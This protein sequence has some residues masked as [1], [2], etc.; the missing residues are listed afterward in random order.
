MSISQERKQE[1]MKQYARVANDTGSVEVQVAVLT[2]RIKNLTEHLGV[3]KKDTQAKRGLKALVARR[4]K[5]LRYLRGNC[6]NR[7]QTV[8]KSLGIRG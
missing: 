1:L 2:E 3:S 6:E 5:L 4:R 8:I 7:Y